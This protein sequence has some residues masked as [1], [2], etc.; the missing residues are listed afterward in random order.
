MTIRLACSALALLVASPALAGNPAPIAPDPIFVAA[1]PAGDWS[2]FY[3][4]VRLAWGQLNSPSDE[5]DNGNFGLTLGY[6]VDMGNWVFGTLTHFEDTNFSVSDT[7]LSAVPISA[8]GIVR[9]GARV[10]YDGGDALYYGMGGYTNLDVAGFG[11]NDGYFVGVGYERMVTGNTSITTEYIFH[12]FDLGAT[13]WQAE[14]LSFG[15]NFR[16]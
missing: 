8:D 7:T 16:F 5:D 10:G 6:D 1:A 9:V 2:G 15:V 3:G 11:S 12:E 4:G 14:S 13:D